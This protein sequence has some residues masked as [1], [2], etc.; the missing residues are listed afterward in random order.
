M[1]VRKLMFIS[2]LA[3]GLL[4]PAASYAGN[5]D[6]RAACALGDYRVTA[7][8]PYKVGERTGKTVYPRLAG[9][10]VFIEA[11]PG[12][13]AEWL[14]LDFMRH[15][16]AMQAGWPMPDCALDMKDVRVQ[17]EPAGWGYYV[18]LIAK[19]PSDAKELLRRVELQLA[20]PSPV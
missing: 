6:R 17:V 9:A 19:D 5:S 14:R 13:T 18:K 12:I 1:F 16:S 11:Q 8:T 10:L 20:Q 2:G 7:V 3:A 4:G 15:I